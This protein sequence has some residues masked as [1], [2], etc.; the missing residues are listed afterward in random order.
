MFRKYNVSAI[1]WAIIVMVLCGIPGRDILNLPFLDWLRPDKIV[2][3]ILF[4]VQSWLLIRWF[5]QLPE[6]SPLQHSAKKYAVL[7]TIF[8]GILVE[9]LQATVFIDRSGDVRDAAADALGA[10]CGLWIFN[11]LSKRKTAH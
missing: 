10:F 4:G 8:Y 11:W 7:I 5:L 2:H 1:A 6:T 9:V 3:L